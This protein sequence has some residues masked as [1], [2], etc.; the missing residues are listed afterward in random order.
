MNDPRNDTGLHPP[1]DMTEIKFV[2][3]GSPPPIP[4]MAKSLYYGVMDWAKDG[5]KT[6]TQQ[7]TDRRLEICTGCEHFKDGRCMVCGCFLKFKA[8][9]ST[10][11]CPIGKW[12]TKTL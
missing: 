7:E 12:E 3:G 1:F 10:G 2:P 4:D 8:A 6:Q 9:L 11:T 5:F